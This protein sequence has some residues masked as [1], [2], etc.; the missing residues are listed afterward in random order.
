MKTIP[1]LLSLAVLLGIVQV[2]PAATPSAINY[3]GRL[4]NA[5]GVPQ[6]GDRAMGVKIYDATTGGTLLYSETVGNVA[7]DAN[8]VYGFQFG[9]GTPGSFANVLAASAEQWLELMVDGVA[10]VPRQKILA[11]PFALLAGGLPVGTVSSSM[12]ANGGVNPEDLSPSVAASIA[13]GSALPGAT[14]IVTA[15][16]GTTAGQNIFAIGNGTNG[17]FLQSNGTG[18]V[19]WAE[20]SALSNASVNG[21]LD[22][23]PSASRTSLGL[24]TAA[25]LNYGTAAGNLVRLDATTGK[26]PSVDG[27]LLTNIPSGEAPLG[28]PSTTGYI[29]S[30]TT[31]G[32]RSWVAP[33]GVSANADFA[34]TQNS[35]S[36]FSSVNSGAV[37][38]TLKLSG[39]VV[40]VGRSAA[41]GGVLCQDL[42]KAPT[43]TATLYGLNQRIDWTPN[44]T[45]S[46][47]IAGVYSGLYAYGANDLTGSESLKGYVASVTNKGDANV[48]EI[49]G[50]TTHLGNQTTTSGR[51][52]TNC[53]GFKANIPSCT[54]TAPITTAYG[55]YADKQSRTGVTNGYGFYQADSADINY[56]NGKTGIGALPTAADPTKLSV[57]STITDTTAHRQSIN[58]YSTFTPSGNS[59][60]YNYNS[61]SMAAIKTGSGTMNGSNSFNGFNLTAYQNGSGT[62]A[63]MNSIY[64]KGGNLGSGTVTAFSS[65]KIPAQHLGGAGSPIT[66]LYGINIGKQNGTG[67]TNAYGIYQSDEGDTNVF[68]GKTGIGGTPNANAILD[69]QSTTKA[70]M[71]PR[72]TKTQR[73]AIASPTAGMV[74]YQNDNT[75]GLRTYNG[76]NWMRYT[77]TAD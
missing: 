75:P 40:L 6:Q 16:G 46:G 70:F 37:V 17:Y 9:S 19:T 4:T 72:M 36:S 21:V 69:A 62:V 51:I 49:D 22:D 29:L 45:T 66:N 47:T 18:G 71:P 11:V 56:F 61:I 39:G 52:L 28:N 55:F 68:V 41:T 26:L 15:L 3:Q 27:S 44:S 59:D 8:G 53:I 2:T 10:Q 33:G 35:V 12:I 57:T 48:Y 13:A 38:D 63:E 58:I 42:Y 34:L 14:D 54:P 65:I 5:A 24:G 43:S 25:T 31:G 23:N 74:V 32:T 7:V 20:A 73:D 76:T 77:E 67:V 64:L 50:Y 60:T 1:R 30:S